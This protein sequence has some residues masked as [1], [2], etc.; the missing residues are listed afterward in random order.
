MELY[1]QLYN[2]VWD[3]FKYDT[4]ICVKHLHV[5]HDGVCVRCE[6][7]WEAFDW[8]SQVRANV[9]KR[10]SDWHR[11][12]D[13]LIENGLAR[14]D[15]SEP[16]SVSLV[17]NDIAYELYTNCDTDWGNAFDVLFYV[18]NNPDGLACAKEAWL[19]K[20]LMPNE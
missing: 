5:M 2:H 17:F 15:L 1:A 8:H 9:Y 16:D 18:L 10:E 13:V 14:W 7:H 6:T 3:V 4:A 12:W 19:L 11:V 20:L